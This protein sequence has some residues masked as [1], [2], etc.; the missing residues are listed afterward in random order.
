M[1]VKKVLQQALPQRDRTR[2]VDNLFARHLSSDERAIASEFY[3][4]PDQIR[5]MV[6][7]GMFFGSHGYEHCWMNNL[8]AEEQLREIRL[9]LTF[10]MAWV[11]QLTT[12][13]VLPVRRL[14]PDLIAD[15]E[16]L[17]LFCRTNDA[18]GRR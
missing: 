3:M 12:G 8:T 1:F 10:L 15:V 7:S 6:R 2:I 18:V 13:Y 16:A 5:M 17:W 11:R 14:Q 4:S 9:S